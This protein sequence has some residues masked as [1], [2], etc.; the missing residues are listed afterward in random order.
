MMQYSPASDYPC[1]VVAQRACNANKGTQGQSH[2]FF[3]QW[4]ARQATA[5]GMQGRSQ[6]ASG[7]EEPGGVGAQL[8]MLL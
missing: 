8:C 3:L 5:C 6:C 1:S 7:L 2:L 4:Q